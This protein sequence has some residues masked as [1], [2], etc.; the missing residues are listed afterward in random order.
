MQCIFDNNM[1]KS[2]TLLHW[3]YRS[4][5]SFPR[6]VSFHRRVGGV[7]EGSVERGFV[8]KF[9]LSDVIDDTRWISFS[10]IKYYSSWIA[11]LTTSATVISSSPSRSTS[12]SKP[13]SCV[14]CVTPLHVVLDRNKWRL[15]R[16]Y[17]LN[18][19]EKNRKYEFSKK[20]I[21]S[22]QTRRNERATAAD[23]DVPPPWVVMADGGA[24]HMHAR[25]KHISRCVTSDDE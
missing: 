9:N 25:A 18:V 15:L 16:N 11:I 5:G 2:R 8:D 1:H 12:P 24:K 13:Y 4:G 6:D 23:V 10:P 20:H 17:A 22:Y 3:L 14:Q 21:H 19:A 7:S